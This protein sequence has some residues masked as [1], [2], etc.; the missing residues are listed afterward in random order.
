[1]AVAV[2]GPA[3][4][5]GRRWITLGTV[6][7]RVDSSQGIIRVRG[8]DRYREVRL[9]VQRRAVRIDNARIQFAQQSTPQVL[10]IRRTIGPGECTAPQ[11]L[12]RP[13]VRMIS[14]NVERQSRGARSIVSAQGRW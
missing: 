10:T 13:N 8:A 12:R 6:T 9:C 4:P 11:A 2:T 3:E 1:M 7:L 14:L 5:Q